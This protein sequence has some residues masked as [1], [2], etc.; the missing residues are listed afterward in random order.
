MPVIFHEGDLLLYA[1]DETIAQTRN[2]CGIFVQMLLREAQRLR[3]ADDAGHVGRAA[4]HP[5]FL[6]PARHEAGKFQSRTDV[7]HA[8]PFGP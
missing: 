7:Q 1:G 8:H 5:A 4:A 6:M 2:V 3:Q